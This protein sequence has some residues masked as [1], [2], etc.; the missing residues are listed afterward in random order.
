MRGRRSPARN[1]IVPRPDASAVVSVRPLCRVC[2]TRQK[3]VI[4][5]FAA[6]HVAVVG[7]GG[8]HATNTV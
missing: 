6:H 1:R 5:V 7:V 3:V 4:D 8:L 2:M